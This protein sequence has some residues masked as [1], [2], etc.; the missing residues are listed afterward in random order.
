MLETLS[1]LTLRAS[2]TSRDVGP[3]LFAQRTQDEPCLSKYVPTLR[4]RPYCLIRG[5]SIKQELGK[6]HRPTGANETARSTER[7]RLIPST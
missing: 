5:E 1:I 7:R 6:D 2:R 3:H 4:R